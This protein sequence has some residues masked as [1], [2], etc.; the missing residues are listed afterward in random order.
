MSVTKIQSIPT[1]KTTEVTLD[2]LALRLEIE[3][4]NARYCHALDDGNLQNWPDF[5]TEDGFYSI[6]ARENFDANLP[7]GLVYC[8][9]RG[10]MKDRAFA[11]ANTAMFAPRYLRHHLSNTRVIKEH[12]DGV[13]E[14]TANYIVLQVLHDDPVSTIHQAGFYKD[15]FCRTETGILL[16]QKRICVYENLM[17]PNAV[18]LP[19]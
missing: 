10:M 19:V 9:G 1:K 17:I 8:E 12:A 16:L 5:F 3:E 14:A 11:I 7:V 18:V 15:E 4:F 6:T 13:I 2:R